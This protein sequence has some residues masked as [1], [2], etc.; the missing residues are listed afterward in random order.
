[1][2]YGC[3]HLMWVPFAAETPEQPGKL[4]AYG[5]PVE[6]GALNKITETP[7]MNE[8]KGYGNNGLQEYV[9]KFKECVLATEV[10][11]LARADASAIYG[12]KIESETKKNLRFR[13]SD[14]PPYGGAGFVNNQVIGGKDCA[15]GVFY[16]KVK[17]MLQ[18]VE[19]NTS[20]ENI[21]LA[22][23]ALQFTA[24]ASLSTDWKI[25][26]PLFEDGEAGTGAEQA[27]A[28]LKGMFDGTST[29]IGKDQTEPAS[30]PAKLSGK[31]GT[32]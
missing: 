28:W 12:A 27:L 31:A 11:S 25:E 32:V 29:D 23:T 22:N 1:M 6:L 16:P 7:A 9:N 20:G 26:S 21:T 15:V 8:A 14:S 2:I 17:A 13:S 3:E 5:T 24:S 19:Y 18:G 30:A 4:P 10:T